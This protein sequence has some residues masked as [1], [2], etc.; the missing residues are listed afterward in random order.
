ME[1][2]QDTIELQSLNLEQPTKI[3]ECP[4]CGKVYQG[5]VVGDNKEEN[6]IQ[7]CNNCAYKYT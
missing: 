1:N 4:I 7:V 6:N 5:Y 3:Y 2:G